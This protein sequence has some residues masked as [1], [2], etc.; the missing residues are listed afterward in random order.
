MGSNREGYSMKDTL[1][2][3]TPD[4]HGII[5][6]MSIIY[7]VWRHWKGGVYTV[8]DIKFRA[9]LNE[10]EVSYLQADCAVLFSRSLLNFHGLTETGEQRFVRMEE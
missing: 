9:D 1:T 2:F 6:D 7:K 10:W 8:I 5:P 4:I 3:E